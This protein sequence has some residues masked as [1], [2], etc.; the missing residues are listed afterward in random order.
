ML[1]TLV[2]TNGNPFVEYQLQQELN[3]R[4][5]EAVDHYMVTGWLN[6]AAVLALYSAPSWDQSGQT[7]TARVA[8]LQNLFNTAPAMP[9]G[10]ADGYGGSGW[11]TIASAYA[12]ML[13]AKQIELVEHLM[14]LPGGTT[15]ATILS[16]MTGV[17]TAPAGIPYAYV[18]NSVGFTDVWI[19]D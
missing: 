2:T 5:V 9:P 4:Q 15:A 1:Q 11:T 16:A 7:I 8:F 6:A 12:Q 18:F 19:D 17:Q 13:Y 10:N 3:K 14:A